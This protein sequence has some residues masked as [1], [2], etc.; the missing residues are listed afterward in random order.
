MHTDSADPGYA[1]Q[2]LICTGPSGTGNCLDKDYKFDTCYD[3]P[4]NLTNNAATFAPLT[5][6]FY[7]DIY[8]AACDSNCTSPTGCIQAHVGYYSREKYNLTAL[9]PGWDRLITS[10]DCHEGTTPP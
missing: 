6:D 2:L 7:C 5:I 1:A 3:L 8:L 10:F 4:G 9:A